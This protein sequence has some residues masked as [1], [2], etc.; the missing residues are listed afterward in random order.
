MY[1]CIY[2]YRY[3]W[4]WIE[5]GTLLYILC[6]VQNSKIISDKTI[7]LKNWGQKHKGVL[8]GLADKTAGS[9]SSFWVLEISGDSEYAENSSFSVSSGS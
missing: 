2:V 8:L 4:K 5:R 3:I 6:N 7:F 1:I 9:E